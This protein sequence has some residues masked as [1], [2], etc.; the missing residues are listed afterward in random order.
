MADRKEVDPAEY[1][2]SSIRTGDK[3]DGQLRADTSMRHAQG[4][5]AAVQLGDAVSQAASHY[6]QFAKFPK[7]ILLTSV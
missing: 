5:M 6:L 7:R 2:S 1:P 3:E 4:I